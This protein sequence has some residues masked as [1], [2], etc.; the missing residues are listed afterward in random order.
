MCRRET[1]P[2]NPAFPEGD[3]SNKLTVALCAPIK[4][5]THMYGRFIVMVKGLF[6]LG[7]L[8]PTP[9]IGDASVLC[10]L[11]RFYEVNSSLVTISL[12]V[13]RR[14]W[15][16]A[17]RTDSNQVFP[18]HSRSRN[19]C[20]IASFLW[21]SFQSVP[22]EIALSKQPWSPPLFP[23]LQKTTMNFRSAM[24]LSHW[25]QRLGCFFL[26]LPRLISHNQFPQ[27]KTK[28]KKSKTVVLVPPLFNQRRNSTLASTNWHS[29]WFEIKN[30][31]WS[32]R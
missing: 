8:D 15:Y 27:K 13:L 22:A 32:R 28:T 17:L 31:F 11:G 7:M 9:L 16:K 2:A 5:T 14:H 1:I 25:M 4:Q 30:P 6:L 3:V 21:Q 19:T 23:R 20:C 10:R 29:S 12:G 26:S 18:R 24:F